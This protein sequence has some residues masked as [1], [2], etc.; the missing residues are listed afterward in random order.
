MFETKQASLTQNKQPVYVSFHLKKR[1]KTACSVS[2]FRTKPAK[3]LI[4]FLP[5]FTVNLC[6]ALIRAT[7]A[8][9][10]PRS[11]GL[12]AIWS[13]ISSCSSLPRKLRISPISVSVSSGEISRAASRPLFRFC[14]ASTQSSVLPS[15]FCF[16]CFACHP[17]REGCQR[18]T[19]LAVSQRPAARRRQFGVNFGS[20]WL[21][22]A[23]DGSCWPML[24][25]VGS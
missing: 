19:L 12:C 4:V 21:M 15:L 7:H 8:S 6:E 14:F 17:I 3:T 2:V 10:S 5:L 13:C 25:H 20:C 23:H 11:I 22:L 18:P 9:T 24:A 16:L 1:P